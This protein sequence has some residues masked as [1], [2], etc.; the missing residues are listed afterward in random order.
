M[1]Q[2]AVAKIPRTNFRVPFHIFEEARALL[3]L[4]AAHQAGGQLL[5]VAAS[6]CA[7]TE[8]RPSSVTSL[9]FNARSSGRPVGDFVPWV[10]TSSSSSDASEGPDTPAI[11]R[12]ALAR[13]WCFVFLVF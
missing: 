1:T 11:P 2:T 8:H 5:R 12:V 9:R 4:A 6:H 10:C 13:V 7:P 3:G